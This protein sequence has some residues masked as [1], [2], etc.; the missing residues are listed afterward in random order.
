M[1]KV[2]YVVCSEDED[3]DT[4]GSEKDNLDTDCDFES[5]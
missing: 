2:E 5:H 4:T 3:I 1:N